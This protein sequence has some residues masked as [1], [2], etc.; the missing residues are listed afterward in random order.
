MPVTANA[1]STISTPSAANS[2]RTTGTRGRAQLLL[3]P[4]RAADHLHG[5]PRGE[6]ASSLPEVVEQIAALVDE[7]LV[8]IV[9]QANGRLPLRRRVAKIDDRALFVGRGAGSGSIG[10]AMVCVDVQMATQAMI[11]MTASDASWWKMWL[12]SMH[13]TILGRF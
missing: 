1:S 7:R 4:N 10:A 8:R 3:L 11:A 13:T 9:R 12:T 6:L 5:D 2:V